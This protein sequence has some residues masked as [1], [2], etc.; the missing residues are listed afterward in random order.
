V[1]CGGY[2]L[3]IARFKVDFA[4][5]GK[6]VIDLGG[7]LLDFDAARVLVADGTQFTRTTP[8]RI[9]SL[10]QVDDFVMDRIPSEKLIDRCADWGTQL[11]WV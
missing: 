1:I 2:L 5:I 7:D 6:S 3:A 4:V 8:V 10:A 11:Y 9:A